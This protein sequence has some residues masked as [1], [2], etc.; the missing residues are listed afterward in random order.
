[1]DL[2]FVS[3]SVTRTTTPDGRVVR[4]PPPAVPT[5]HLDRLG[6]E[7]PFSPS[8]GEHSEDLLE[9][10]GFSVAEIAALRGAGTIA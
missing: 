2:P 8:Y 9:E 4:L 5:D 10:I 3:E 6:G 7:I 1:M